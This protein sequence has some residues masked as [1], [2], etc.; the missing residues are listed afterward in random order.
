MAEQ[1]EIKDGTGGTTRVGVNS[2]NSL[3]V[4]DTVQYYK[5]RMTYDDNN[6]PEYIGLAE[7]GSETSSAVWQI[8]I[9]THDASGNTTAVDFAS[10]TA[11]FD[12]VWD[13][14][15]SYTYS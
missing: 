7:P 1:C 4:G 9:L 14:R 2:D 5:Q 13:D 10:G 3:K 8:K 12:K 15:A 6:Y 11:A